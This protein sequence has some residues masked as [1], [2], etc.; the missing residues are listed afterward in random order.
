ML[1]VL[2]N[3]CN[4]TKDEFLS[5]QEKIA[6][7]DEE[8]V[9]CPSYTH[10]ANFNLQNA[11]LGAQNVST[12]EMGAYT[13]EVAASQLSSFNVKYCLVGHSERRTY[14]HETYEETNKKIKELLKY[15]IIPILCVGESKEEKALNKTKDI[16]EKEILGAIQDLSDSE[17]L[18]L[19]IAYEPIWSIGTGNIPTPTEITEVLQIIK[20]IF[21][22]NTLLYGGSVTEETVTTLQQ[23][24]LIDGYLLGGISLKV[25]NLKNFLKKMTN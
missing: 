20:N 7:I 22:T 6:T 19:I 13:G 1:I 25:E 3:K 16:I 5:Y 9:L 23:C 17:K 10:L 21:P 11:S 4:L 14:Q 18:K 24:P 15:D 2:N 12:T 8:F